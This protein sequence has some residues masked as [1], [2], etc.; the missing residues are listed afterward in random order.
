MIIAGENNGLYHHQ[1]QHV[2]NVQLCIQIFNLCNFGSVIMRAWNVNRLPSP[3]KSVVLYSAPM[4]EQ[5]YRCFSFSSLAVKGNCRQ[6]SW[7]GCGTSRW[8]NSI[9]LGRCWRPFAHCGG[10]LLVMNLVTIDFVE[11][12]WCIFH[13][14]CE[15]SHTDFVTLIFLLEGS[16]CL[17]S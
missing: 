7:L 8:Y 5:P 11:L 15:C 9:G 10:E 1:Q 13:I 2:L 17:W 14:V 4:C 6:W 3:K 16:S 12:F